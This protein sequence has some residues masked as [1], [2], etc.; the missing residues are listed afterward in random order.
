MTKSKYSCGKFAGAYQCAYSK[1]MLITY[2]LYG[3]LSYNK[4]GKISLINSVWEGLT[5][6][7]KK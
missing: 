1:V 5:W 2:K 3:I 4:S 6:N 7:F